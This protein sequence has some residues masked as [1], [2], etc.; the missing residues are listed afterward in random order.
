MKKK[1][2]RRVKEQIVEKTKPEKFLE[3]LKTFTYFGN[4]ALRGIAIICSYAGNKEGEKGIMEGEEGE[5]IFGNSGENINPNDFDC[6]F[7]YKN[8]NEIIFFPQL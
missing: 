8:K 1:K 7:G 4:V 2:K 5:F 3:T 6:V